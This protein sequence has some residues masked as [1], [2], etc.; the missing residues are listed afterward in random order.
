MRIVN[1]L[2]S[3]SPG[4]ARAAFALTLGACLLALS[5]CSGEVVEDAATGD[6]T[7]AASG[8][9]AEFETKVGQ[10][11]TERSAE[12]TDPPPAEGP[13]AAPGKK[14][15]VIACIMAAEGC[16]RESRT[17]MEAGEAIGWDMTLVDTGSLPDKMNA[18]VQQAIDDR[19]DGIIVQAI[20]MQTLAAPL[21][22]AKQ[23]GIKIVCFACVNHEGIADQTI[24]SEE[25]F[26]D[27]GYALGAAMYQATGGSPKL[28][29]MK[30]E[31]FGVVG[32]RHEG[33]VKF[34]ED[35]Q[36]AGG[37]CEIVETLDFLVTEL[38]TRVPQIAAGAVRQ[39]P[40]AN[41]IWM[42][43]DSAGSFITQGLR[44][45]N[46]APGTVGLYG[47][48]GNEANITA[49]RNGDYQMASMAGP[50][51]WV[52]YAQVDGL[53]RLFQGEQP[54]DDV[55]KIRLVTPDSLPENDAWSGDIDFKPGYLKVWGVG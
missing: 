48:D 5:A 36:A 9:L 14:V 34:F 17:A 7:G 55:V 42:P 50:F 3:R 45:V 2:I 31:S 47:F 26:F 4:R 23:A 21:T 22:K 1:P 29:V 32:I 6:D 33:T 15:Y 49:V 25:S 39:H 27:D 19:A 37:D 30:D 12:I 8:D 46:V 54:V 43:Y 16:A 20:D 11:V 52:G 24:P 10:I 41:A 51:E 13:E 53:N 40:E 18:A 28:I 38:T 35:C 44:Q